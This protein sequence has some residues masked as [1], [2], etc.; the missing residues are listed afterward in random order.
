MAPCWPLFP[1][2][3]GGPNYW[4]GGFCW[5]YLLF[6]CF[7]RPSTLLAP[8]GLDLGRFGP[9]FWRFLV[10]I[11]LTI[12]KF[13]ANKAPPPGLL[14]AGGVTRTAK[15]CSPRS[16][17]PWGPWGCKNWPRGPQGSIEKYEKFIF[18]YFI[19][20]DRFWHIWTPDSNS[21]LKVIHG[22]RL[23]PGFGHFSI[24]ST[25]LGPWG[26]CDYQFSN[27]SSSEH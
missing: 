13:L 15:N 9:P 6:R 16:W 27:N 17:R 12:S 25:F 18:I 23:K 5:V 8:S 14:R 4:M 20:L 11:F 10:P 7:E 19:I 22:Y 3:Y 2:K 1:I 21:A 24:K 26:P